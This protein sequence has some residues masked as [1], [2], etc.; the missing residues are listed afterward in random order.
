MQRNTFVLNCSMSIC[1]KPNDEHLSTDDFLKLA[2][3]VWP[4]KYDR[5]KTAR[6]LQHTLNISAWQGN[7]LVG[8]VRILSD[9]YLFSTLPEI[10]VHPEF[11]GL[12]VGRRLMELAWE[13]APTSL[14]FGAQPGNS[15]FFE[16]MGFE[17]GLEG[18]FR[19]KPRQDELTNSE[20]EV[21]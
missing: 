21:D 16:K 1:Y 14:F 11:Q 5:L 17:R 7:Q 15:D 8:C 9:G 10:L 19:R 6:A 18:Y 4:D 20:L 3:A 2:Q 13:N 12:G